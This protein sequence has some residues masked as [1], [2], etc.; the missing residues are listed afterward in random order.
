MI[1]SVAQQLMKAGNDLTLPVGYTID[2]LESV[3]WLTGYFDKDVA[4]SGRQ[5]AEQSGTNQW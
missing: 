3:K 4:I 1:A 2:V 5:A